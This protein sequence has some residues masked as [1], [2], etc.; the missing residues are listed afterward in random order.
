MF[1]MTLCGTKWMRR[2]SHHL[3]RKNIN[4]YKKLQPIHFCFPFHHGTCTRRV[5]KFC[6]RNEST[7]KGSHLTVFLFITCIECLKWF[8]GVKVKT[9]MYLMFEMLFCSYFGLDHTS[10][11]EV[12]HTR[13]DDC[14][15]VGYYFYLQSHYITTHNAHQN[16]SKFQIISNLPTVKICACLSKLPGTELK[17]SVV[18]K[19]V[20]QF[21]VPCVKQGEVFCYF[22]CNFFYFGQMK[23]SWYS[24]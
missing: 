23:L 14:Q 5:F 22:D 24:R 2:I 6:P 11:L 15:F 18:H 8:S 3:K 21:G 10:S 17:I 4:K 1:I 9:D 13:I 20:E 12:I 19:S 7:E 16:L